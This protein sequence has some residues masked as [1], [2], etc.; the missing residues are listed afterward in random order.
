MIEDKSVQ[1]MLNMLD[2]MLDEDAAYPQRLEAYEFLMEDCE[3]IVDTMLEKSY[4]VDGDTGKMLMEVLARYR[5]NKAVFMGLVSYLYKGDDVALFARLIGSYGDEQGIQ[6]LKT[7]CEE[8]EPDYNE[9]MEIRNA[10]EQLGGDFDMRED[11]SDDP[12]YRYLKGL[13]EDDDR[14][15]PFENLWKD[16]DSEE[17]CD[18]GCD[19]ECHGDGYCHC[20][21]GD[22]H[23][24]DD[25]ECDCSD[26]SQDGC[27]CHCGGKCDCHRDGGRE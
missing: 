26:S 16:G 21:D 6:V 3:A 1:E 24:H 10:V 2:V 5:G 13:D 22:G 23:C 27:G 8:Y 7:F 25:E 11:F 15:S 9:Y 12:L 17:D 4:A 14:K 18:C 20:H 19:D